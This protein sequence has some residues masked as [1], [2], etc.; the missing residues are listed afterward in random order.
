M[1]RRRLDLD[2]VGRRCAADR[3]ARS[4]LADVLPERIQAVCCGVGATSMQSTS[5][6]TI[7]D[8]PAR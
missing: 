4:C 3:L 6:G 8:R 7:G 5:E 2:G 1:E